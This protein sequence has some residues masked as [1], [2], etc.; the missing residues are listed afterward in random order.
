[1]ALA[2]TGSFLDYLRRGRCERSAGN[3]CALGECLMSGDLRGPQVSCAG[4][5]TN[6]RIAC[7]AV[8]LAKAG[9]DGQYFCS[10]GL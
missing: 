1:M 8:A 7:R 4:A 2:A 5:R 6:Q 10:G 3:T 9:G